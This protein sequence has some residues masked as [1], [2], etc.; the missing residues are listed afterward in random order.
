MVATGGGFIVGLRETSTVAAD[1]HGRRL[2][3]R[4]FV[5]VD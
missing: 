4:L 5:K 3:C 1:C 2:E